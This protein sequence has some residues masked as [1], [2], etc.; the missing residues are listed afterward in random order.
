MFEPHGTNPFAS[1]FFVVI[2]SRMDRAPNIYSGILYAYVTPG[3]EILQ[4]IFSQS[5]LNSFWK[6]FIVMHF[7]KYFLQEN[8]II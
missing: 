6:A 3:D 4:H 2:Y 5:P 1:H 7:I 8:I